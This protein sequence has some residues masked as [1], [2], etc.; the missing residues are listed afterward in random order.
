M[1]QSKILLYWKSLI[2]IYIEASCTI[3]SDVLGFDLQDNNFKQN[4]VRTCNAGL[5]V[6]LVYTIVVGMEHIL[7]EGYLVQ[8]TQELRKH[9]YLKQ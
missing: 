8:V 3:S 5:C 9:F 2:W 7:T 6:T 1:E 4:S